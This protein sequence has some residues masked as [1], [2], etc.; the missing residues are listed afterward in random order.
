MTKITSAPKMRDIRLAFRIFDPRRV[1]TVESAHK[2]VAEQIG[3][4]LTL[5]QRVTH[6]CLGLE[7][8]G[9][10]DLQEIREPS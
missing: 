8:C 1:R 10:Q 3:R 5:Y 7:R 6:P 4:K 9:K 2:I